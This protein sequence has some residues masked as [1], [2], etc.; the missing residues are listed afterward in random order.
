MRTFQS[1]IEKST[2]EL[3][4]KKGKKKKG[5]LLKNPKTTIS[6]LT[7]CECIC[8]FTGSYEKPQSILLMYFQI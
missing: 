3:K 1:S 7:K 5:A 2:V 8:N 6:L 4:K